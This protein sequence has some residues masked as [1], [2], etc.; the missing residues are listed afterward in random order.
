MTPHPHVHLP[1]KD[2]LSQGKEA[3]GLTPSWK[4]GHTVQAPRL[5][6]IFVWDLKLHT[7]EEFHI[8]GEKACLLRCPSLCPA[9]PFLHR[10]ML[11]AVG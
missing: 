9:S 7:E 3:P 1:R 2:F 5:E 11:A 10:S 8:C 6:S 4:D